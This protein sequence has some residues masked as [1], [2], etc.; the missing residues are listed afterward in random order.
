M[1]TQELDRGDKLNGLMKQPDIS[2]SR[3]LLPPQGYEG[4]KEGM[5][6]SDSEA[7]AV[8]WLGLSTTLDG[9]AA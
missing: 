1:V 3:K 6:S 4:H 2:D 8:L 5:V 9:G 7:E